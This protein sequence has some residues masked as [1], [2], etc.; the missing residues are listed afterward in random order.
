MTQN[1]SNYRE[2][3]CT[4]S[5]FQNLKYLNL[6]GDHL[7]N[8]SQVIALLSS[9]I[10]T[11]DLSSNL[12][13]RLN[14]STFQKFNNLKFLN[15]SQTNLSNFGFDTFYHQ[16]KLIVLDISFNHLKT[17]D[18]TLLLRNFQNLHSL[19]LEGNDLLE[20]NSVSQP[21]FPRL[22]YLGI[23]KNRFDCHYLAKFL[24]KWPNLKLLHNPSNRTHI[25]G[26]DCLRETDQQP[27]VENTTITVVTT[28][29]IY[30]KN[31]HT[32][33]ENGKISRFDCNFQHS[34]NDSNTTSVSCAN[35]M[36]IDTSCMGN[37][38]AVDF[39][40]ND[41]IVFRS[42]ENGS[43]LKCSKANLQNVTS[44][45]ISGNHLQNISKIIEFLGSSVKI[46]DLSSNSI[47]RLN[48]STF[49]QFT[50]LEHLN[51]S[52]TNLSNFEYKIFFHQFKLKTLDL[53]Y[54]HLK[55]EYF[56]SSLQSSRD[57]RTLFLEGNDLKTL[58]GLTQSSFPQLSLLRISR[59]N[60]SCEYLE[61]IL[62]GW[63]NLQLTH[64]GVDCYSVNQTMTDKIGKHDIQPTEKYTNFIESTTNPTTIIGKTL[65]TK[66]IEFQ[67]NESFDKNNKLFEHPMT[68]VNS[69]STDVQLLKYLIF[70]MSSMLCIY[71]VVKKPKSFR[72]FEESLIA[73]R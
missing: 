70:A 10:E 46:M 15:L 62:D 44:F 11:L 25:G 53:S 60:F 6:S 63:T 37:S 43:T 4:K 30:T 57:L 58:H 32:S 7:E 35:I 55:S 48:F 27:L 50:E 69:L 39:N 24:L 8:T 19:Y 36:E 72:M 65:Q 29:K 59:N 56:I 28:K 9:S 14:V 66:S 22:T 61:F 31:Q 38:L 52:C 40:E 68:A 23:S 33:S 13:G 26:V 67:R 51:L 41:K 42:S 3:H 17:I 20:I 18:F 16:T 71:F 47:D 54:N 12:I 34:F 5:D 49:Q 64:K 73:K 2:F 1:F 21:I 45:N